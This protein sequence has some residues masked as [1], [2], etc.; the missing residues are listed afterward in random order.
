MSS[1]SL[2]PV[3]PAFVSRPREQLV[4][5]ARETLAAVKAGSYTDQHDGTY[6]FPN[7]SDI[8]D[9]TTYFPADALD[10]WE[11]TIPPARSTPTECVIH[12]ASTL[13]AIRLYT[14]A[15]SEQPLGVLN[16]ASAT[17]PGGGFLGGARAQEETLARS[18]NL[19]SSL[20][21]SPAHP[22]Y[23]SH[24]RQHASPDPRYSH[25]M[26]LTRNV[27]FARDDAGAWLAPV[28]ADVLTSAAVNANTLHRWLNVPSSAP[29]PDEARIEVEGI[30]R[31]RMARILSAF[32]RNLDGKS[33]IILG[34]FGTGAFRNNVD[35]V[36]RTW[37]ELLQ[38]PFKDVFAR[39]VFAVIDDGSWKM[40]KEMFTQV[41]VA[42]REKREEAL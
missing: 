4:L 12:L 35:F 32:A 39:V 28:T 34:S 26:L 37:A 19:Y 16:F 23:A 42:F 41:G 10:D 31:A 17:S 25:A 24:H 2:N 5:I 13:Q 1:H 33:T 18:S 14:S 21:S 27:H 40:F 3:A 15:S 8:P 30:M 20:T 11:T 7:L 9:S 6:P 36:A 29:L 38:G 22:F